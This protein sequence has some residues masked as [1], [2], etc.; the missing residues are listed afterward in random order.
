VSTLANT[1]DPDHRMPFRRVMLKLSGEALMGGR[2]YGLDPT[3]LRPIAADI[4]RT[5]DLGLEVCVV[6]GAGNIFRGVSGAA[7]GMDRTTADSIGMLGTVINALALQNAIEQLGYETRVQ[8]AIPMPTVSEPF[9]RRR[10]IRHLEKRRIVIFAAGTG[11]PFVTTDTGAALRASEL[12]C[13]AIL[14]GT[15]VDGVYDRDPKRFEGA[16]RFERLTYMD[17]LQKDLKVMDASAISMARENHIPIL[18]FSIKEEGAFPN[19]AAGRGRF[20]IIC[21]ED[22]PDVVRS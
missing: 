8:S 17:V 20:T 22:H 16:K 12:Q 2:E 11:N 5:H 6:I 19:V 13:D 18:I 3:V 10:A 15:S 21:N 7:Q 1:S 9:I 14:K 4:G